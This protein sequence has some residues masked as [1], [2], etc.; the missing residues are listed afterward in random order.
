MDYFSNQTPSHVKKKILIAEDD[1]DMAYLM[2]NAL[3]AAGY[4]VI[5]VDNGDR[6][7]FEY[8][9]HSPDLIILDVMMSKLD[10][11]EVASNIRSKEKLT[12]IFFHSA[13]T[14]VDDVL[15]GLSLGVEDY[16]R[17]PCNLEE[18]ILKV[19][20][21]LDKSAPKYS[22]HWYSLGELEINFLEAKVKHGNKVRSLQRLR[23]EILWELFS[24]IN[25]L[26]P[27]R[28]MITKFWGTYTPENDS[29]LRVHLA[30][31]NKV[32]KMDPNWHIENFRAQGYSLVYKAK[33]NHPAEDKSE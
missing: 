19:N 4:E 7:L 22:S 24:N 13:K 1:D 2:K 3:L 28:K 30:A 10:G 5:L 27:T 14:S 9:Q 32:L 15:I 6:A 21:I 12:P 20:N 33:E 16:L 26:Y 18:F 11:L 23:A 17:K 29:S 31:I 8:S 25:K